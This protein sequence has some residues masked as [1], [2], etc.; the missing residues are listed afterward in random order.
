[1]SSQGFAIEFT[2]ISYYSDDNDEPHTDPQP[3]AP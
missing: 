3:R 1:M 2:T